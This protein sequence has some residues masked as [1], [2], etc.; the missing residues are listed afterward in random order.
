MSSLVVHTRQ[1]VSRARRRHTRSRKIKGVVNVTELKELTIRGRGLVTN[2]AQR[3]YDQWSSTQ[4]NQAK[5]GIHG[6]RTCTRTAYHVV[7]GRQWDIDQ[8]V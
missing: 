8:R 7:E 3:G 4:N 1:R 5:A 2:S 6:E